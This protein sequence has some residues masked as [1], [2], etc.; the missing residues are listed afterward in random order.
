MHRYIILC[1]GRPDRGAVEELVDTYKKR[2]N[3]YAK[4]EEIWVKEVPFRSANDATRVRSEESDAFRA[5]LPKDTFVVALTEEGK[6]FDSLAFAKTLERWAEG[7]ARPVAFLIGGPLGLDRALLKEADAQ[8]SLSPLTFP[9]NVAR[10]L[11]FEQLY[12]AGTILSG[13]T[14]HY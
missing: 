6:T 9:H 2:L 10:A 3:P 1:P 5:R 12:R 8:L 14:Y 11:L 7:G 4:I 13:K